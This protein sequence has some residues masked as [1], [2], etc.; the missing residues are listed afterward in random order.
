MRQLFFG[1]GGG[2]VCRDRDKTFAWMIGE[3]YNVAFG[4]N[5]NLNMCKKHG[6]MK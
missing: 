4:I 1:G 5:P 2:W 3:I 6:T